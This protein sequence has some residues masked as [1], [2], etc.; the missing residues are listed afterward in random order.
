MFDIFEGPFHDTLLRFSTFL[1][2]NFLIKVFFVALLKGL[3]GIMLCVWWVPNPSF[4]AA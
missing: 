3:Y 2:V 4:F 1:A